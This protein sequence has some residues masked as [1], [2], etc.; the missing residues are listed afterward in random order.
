MSLF[1]PTIPTAGQDLSFSQGQLLSNN[2]GLDTVFGMDHYK[3]SDATANKGLHNT[4]TTPLYEQIPTTGTPSVTPPVTTTNAIL[5]AFQNTANIGPLQ[6]SAPPSAGVPTPITML[7]APTAI[8]MTQGNDYPVLDFTGVNIA[9]A[10]LY[11]FDSSNPKAVNHQVAYISYNS[12]YFSMN[13]VFA[14]AGTFFPVTAGNILSIRYITFKPAPTVY[15]T[16]QFFRL[17]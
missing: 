2:S 12:G 7:Q 17:S 13:F 4:V 5:Y 9:N 8:S 16:L 3:F 6:Y 15:W 14:A 10:V 11:I 1:V